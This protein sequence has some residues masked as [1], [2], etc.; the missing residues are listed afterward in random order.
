MRS[1]NN[2][3]IECRECRDGYIFD[4]MA[5][6]LKLMKISRRIKFSLVWRCRLSS[7]RVYNGVDYEVEITIL[8]FET[9]ISARD[10]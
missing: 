8:A 3:M 6:R 2:L 1:C 10:S 5:N 7:N 4:C 9:E